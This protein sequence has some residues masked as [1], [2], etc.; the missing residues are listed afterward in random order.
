MNPALRLQPDQEH[1]TPAQQAEAWRFAD[2]FSSRQLSTE[3]V[4]EREAEAWLC[5]AY[6]VAGLAP[7]ARIYWLDGPLQMVAALAPPNYWNKIYD[8]VKASVWCS[9]D[10]SVVECVGDPVSF[11]VRDSIGDA[12][13]DSV[14]ASIR[15]YWNA[16][17]LASCQFL[18]VYLA[19]PRS[20]PWPGSTRWS[21]AI[22]WARRLR[23]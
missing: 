10:D 16:G 11:S 19:P 4:D 5:Q 21:L 23:W 8:S 2:K 14:G 1:L 12:F 13:Y 9:V 7:P 18:E 17:W 22:G 6:V 20:M 15:A 3:P